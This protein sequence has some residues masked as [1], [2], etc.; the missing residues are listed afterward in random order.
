MFLL[1]PLEYIYY[2]TYSFLHKGDTPLVDQPDTKATSVAM[3]IPFFTLLTL[4][5]LLSINGII[6]DN[7]ITILAVGVGCGFSIIPLNKYFHQ[8]HQLFKE[9]WSQQSRA[10]KILWSCLVIIA[11][12]TIFI[13]FCYL[14]DINHDLKNP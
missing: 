2:R 3:I 10:L 12:I 6:D 9:R 7:G 5:M 4:Y 14:S 8:R 11:G 13:G 1:R